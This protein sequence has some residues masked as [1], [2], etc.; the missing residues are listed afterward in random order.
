MQYPDGIDTPGCPLFL[1]RRLFCRRTCDLCRHDQQYVPH[2]VRF[3]KGKESC[4]WSRSVYQF[5]NSPNNNVRLST[6]T[7]RAGICSMF[8][9]RDLQYRQNG[10]SISILGFRRTDF[11]ICPVAGRIREP[12]DPAL[13]GPPGNGNSSCGRATTIE[14][15]C[16]CRS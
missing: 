15:C 12:H 13:P 16:S 5:I 8:C 4:L 7:S 2:N 9:G 14:S 3:N 11:H 10:F 6:F 1:H